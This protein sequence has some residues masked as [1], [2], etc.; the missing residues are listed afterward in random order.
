MRELLERHRLG[1]RWIV[2]A[3]IVVASAIAALLG[4]AVLVA[5]NVDQDSARRDIALAKNGLDSL[6]SRTQHDLVSLAQWDETVQRVLSKNDT[7][8][9]HRYFGQRLRETSGHDLSFVLNADG[10]P[11][12]ASIEGVN[13]YNDLYDWVRPQADPIVAEVKDSYAKRMA[14]L[15]RSKRS[16]EME[17]PPA[18][19]SRA[20]FRHI[21][22]KSALLVASTIVPSRD[23][24]LLGD[25]LPPVAISVGFLEGTFLRELAN[26]H[27][28]I[29][30]WR[31]AF[32]RSRGGPESRCRC[33]RKGRVHGW[34]GN[35]AGR[36][37]KCSIG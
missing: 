14:L 9:L 32:V 21:D 13:V 20:V 5:H 2:A 36:G 22:H 25:R 17:S 29:S 26:D 18:P 27:S 1:E 3:G 12:Y 6:V 4:L 30:R 37:R 15:P 28:T 16:G 11:V 35:R 33:R 23:A 34:F 31:T 7:A 10:M 24:A 8:W 19:V